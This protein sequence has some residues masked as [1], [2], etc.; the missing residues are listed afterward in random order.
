[1]RIPGEDE[2]AAGEPHQQQAQ[3]PAHELGGRAV[4][5]AALPVVLL[6]PVQVDEHRYSHHNRGRLLYMTGRLQEA[7]KDYDRAL[8][9]RR[10]LPADFPNRPDL[11]NELATSCANLALLHRRQGDWAAAKRVL[12]EGRPHHLAVRTANPRHPTYRQLY[13]DHLGALTTAHAGLL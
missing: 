11:R 8:G 12:L 2:G 5:P 6:G 10:Q 1:A 3:Q 4:R 7:E 13:R 9:I